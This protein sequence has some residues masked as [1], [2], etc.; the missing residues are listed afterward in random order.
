M[1]R[2]LNIF[3]AMTLLLAA[4]TDTSQTGLVVQPDDDKVALFIDTFGVASRD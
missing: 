2:R 4:C 3:F 1:K